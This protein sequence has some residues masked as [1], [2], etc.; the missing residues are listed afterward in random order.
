ME[1]AVRSVL[2]KFYERR[3]GKVDWLLG[4]NGA[5][6][7]AASDTNCASG[8]LLDSAFCRLAPSFSAVQLN[9]ESFLQGDVQTDTTW[10]ET[11]TTMLGNCWAMKGKSGDVSVALVKPIRPTEFVVQHAPVA[12]TVDAGRCCMHACRQAGSA[13]H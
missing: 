3:L 5:R 6:I 12:I 10:L 2:A 8:G 7:L 4:I 11:G 13:Q 9:S 1:L